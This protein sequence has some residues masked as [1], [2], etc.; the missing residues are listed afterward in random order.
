[1]QVISLGTGGGRLQLDSPVQTNQER[2]H[3]TIGWVI[4]V[5][6]RLDST[7]VSLSHEYLFVTLGPRLTVEEQLLHV[8]N[9][10]PAWR[11]Y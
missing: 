5:L 9:D 10:V 11:I 1:M 8:A 6:E 4:D 2:C 7:G 3:C